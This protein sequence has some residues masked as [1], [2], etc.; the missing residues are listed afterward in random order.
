MSLW[1]KI[2][3]RDL[4]QYYKQANFLQINNVECY[5]QT[6]ISDKQRHNWQV[7]KYLLSYILEGLIG[8]TS[9]ILRQL[10]LYFRFLLC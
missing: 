8:Y 3:K 1:S 7:S 10:L 9:S 4:I 6:I 5:F 2:W